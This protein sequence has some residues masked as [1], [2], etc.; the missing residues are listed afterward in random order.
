M[1]LYLDI[2]DTITADP[3]FFAMISHR[4]YACGGEV[5]VVSSRSQEAMPQTCTEIDALGIVHSS[6]YLLPS[7][8]DAQAICPHRE[9]DWFQKHL[10][11][12][13]GYALD[14]EITHA[15][16]DDEKVLFLFSRYAP[17]IRAIH[18]SDRSQLLNLG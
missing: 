17:E 14:N 1:K 5:H 8:G 10:W 3:V 11:L 16:D 12:K 2:D 4:I 13:V 18:V 6:I 7:I 9:L 15:V